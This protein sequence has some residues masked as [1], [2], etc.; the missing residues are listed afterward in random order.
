MFAFFHL[1]TLA[2][3]AQLSLRR[4]GGA[5]PTLIDDARCADPCILHNLGQVSTNPN[6][7]SL[8]PRP[9]SK[10]FLL[11]LLLGDVSAGCNGHGPIHLLCPVAG[12]LGWSWSLNEHG[13]TALCC[14]PSVD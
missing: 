9:N 1:S 14:H 6:L 8:Q 13:W 10:V 4:V 5:V 7:S 2:L 11:L 12:Q 3:S